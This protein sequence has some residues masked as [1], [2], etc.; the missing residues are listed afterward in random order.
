M[1]D[2]CIKS[3]CARVFSSDGINVL[4]CYVSV[5]EGS[6]VYQVAEEFEEVIYICQCIASQHG[7]LATVSLR[8]TFRLGTLT[9][10][11]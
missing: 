7:S 5:L 10:D 1:L 2:R 9:Y 8:R 6:E 11:L 4:I 3:L